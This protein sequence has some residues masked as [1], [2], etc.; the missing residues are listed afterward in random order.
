MYSR[1]PKA[2]SS[3]DRPEPHEALEFL[4]PSAYTSSTARPRTPGY[5]DHRNTTNPRPQTPKREQGIL[6]AR[7]TRQATSFPRPTL[8]VMILLP[9]AVLLYI[10][11]FANG[12]SG[13]GLSRSRRENCPDYRSYAARPH[14]PYTSGQHGLPFQRPV[15]ECRLFQSQAVDDLI[16]EMVGKIADPDL[17]RLF[18]N[19]YP[20]TLDTTVR[21]HVDGG[22]EGAQSFIVTGD[23]NAQWLRDCE[24]GFSMRK[25]LRGGGGTDVGMDPG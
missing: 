12:S 25:K 19:A 15:P 13:S 16:Q 14:P 1:H 23:I 17:A 4:K 18:E 21:W 5:R 20:N 7:K 3:S 22:A 11:S 8:V 2:P 9:A 6:R 10:V 24:F